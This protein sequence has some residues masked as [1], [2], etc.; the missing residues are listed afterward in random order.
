MEV[1][2]LKKAAASGRSM[3]LGSVGIVEP[4]CQY[5]GSC[6]HLSSMLGSW[7]CGN[8][9]TLPFSLKLLQSN[10]NW[11]VVG[12]SEYFSK[13]REVL[14]STFR[15]HR[16]LRGTEDLKGILLYIDRLELK[17]VLK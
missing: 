6:L 7:G 12:F 13:K 5:S 8:I 15:I 4:A 10:S 3:I 11:I 16:T 2:T 9:G 1:G 14:K 17:T